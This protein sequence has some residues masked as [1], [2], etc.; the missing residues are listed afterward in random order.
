[1]NADGADLRRLTDN[2][3]GAAYEWMPRWAPDGSR[4]VFM[5]FRSAPGIYVVNSDGSAQRR[6]V[7]TSDD[8][9]QE[10]AAQPGW[11]PDG[12]RIVFARHGE[13]GFDLYGLTIDGGE[14][15]RIT[16]DPGD[17]IAPAVSPDGRRVAFFSNRAGQFDLHV[18]DVE[19][20]E[21]S[22]LAEHRANP[23]EYRPQETLFQLSAAWSPD[24]SRIAY[25][26]V[27]AGTRQIFVVG[28]DGRGRRQLTS[29]GSNHGPSWAECGVDA[30]R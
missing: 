16:D 13:G 14:S 18:V 11:Y 17:E 4:L 6:L 8:R 10:S 26:S 3:T 12:R 1:M 2:P 24:E 25:V 7:D 21:V 30:E 20:G 9:H 19:T 27:E 28:V 22:Q 29:E 15:I 23:R 5:R